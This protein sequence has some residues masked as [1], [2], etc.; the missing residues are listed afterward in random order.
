MENTQ[1]QPI[2]VIQKIYTKDVSFETVNAPEIFKKQW[3]P[4]SDFN[5]DINYNKLDESNFEVDLT[6]TVTTKNADENAY[7][8][9]VT[10]TGIFTIENMDEK[11]LDAT[12]NTYCPNTLFPYVKRTLDSVIIKGGLLPINISPI[13]FDAIYIQ[14]QQQQTNSSAH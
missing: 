2:F 8:A 5:L 11:Q 12:L 4:T 14:K 9:E 6:I 13:N 10:Q 1:N 3:N 7:I